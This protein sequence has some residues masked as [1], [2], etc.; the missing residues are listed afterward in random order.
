MIELSKMSDAE[1][2]KLLARVDADFDDMI[3]CVKEENEASKEELEKEAE[4]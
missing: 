2:E 4:I 3:D 1:R